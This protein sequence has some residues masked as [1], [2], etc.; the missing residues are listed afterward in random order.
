MTLR[1]ERQAMSATIPVPSRRGVSLIEAIAAFHRLGTS[2]WP[3]DR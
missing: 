3:N 1:A 2:T